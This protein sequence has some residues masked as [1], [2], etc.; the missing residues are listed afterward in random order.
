MRVDYNAGRAWGENEKR[1]P[2]ISAP[3][4]LAELVL[5]SLEADAFR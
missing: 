2:G 5:T 4:K 3:Q 1:L